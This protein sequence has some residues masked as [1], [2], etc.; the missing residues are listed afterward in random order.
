MICAT[1]T[2]PPFYLL[3][4]RPRTTRTDVATPA[5]TGC[6]IVLLCSAFRYGHNQRADAVS[7]IKP[8]FLV[9]LFD[10]LESGRI[11]EARDDRIETHTK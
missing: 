9:T 5:A 10:R 4:P 11:L 2:Q 3:L 1:S 6:L 7:P 8:L